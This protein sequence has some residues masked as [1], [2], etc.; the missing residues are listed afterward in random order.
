[1]ASRGD[2]MRVAI[3]GDAE[4]I[5]RLKA[6]KQT[7]AN[8][9]IRKGLRAGAKEI[10]FETQHSSPVVSGALRISF[11]IKAAR[12]KRG[13]VGVQVVSGEGHFVGET[14]YSGFVALGHRVGPRRLGEARTHVPPNEF[15]KQAANKAEPAALRILEETIKKELE[16]PV[17][18]K[19]VKIKT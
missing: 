12:R 17:K 3:Q 11:L 4:L 9:I 7:E 19:S 14:F 8:K 16:K 1:M 15:M 13:R 10:L 18:A 6:L 2:G 5:K